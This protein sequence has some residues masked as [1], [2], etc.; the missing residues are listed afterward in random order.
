MPFRGSIS[1]SVGG[2][3]QESKYLS[4]RKSFSERQPEGFGLWGSLCCL[5]KPA[6]ARCCAVPKFRSAS[7]GLAQV[8]VAGEG[9]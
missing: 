8:L 3:L 1:A 9:M 6:L 2:G 5:A 4:A 7:V